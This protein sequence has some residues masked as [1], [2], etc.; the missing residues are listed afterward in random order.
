MHGA[1]DY[2]IKPCS[3]RQIEITVTRAMRYRETK[4]GNGSFGKSC[5]FERFGIIGDSLKLETTLDAAAKAASGK[6]S[7]LIS[8]ETGTGKELLSRAIHGNSPRKDGPFLVMDCTNIP[9]T[10]AESIM[11]GHVKG[12][13]T[14]ATEAQEGLF[15]LADGGTLFLDEV[16]ELKPSLQKSLLRVLQDRRFRPVG[17]AKEYTSDFCLISATNRDLKAMV[18]KGK[19]RQ[20][21]YYRLTGISINIPPLRSRPSDINAL[22]DHYIQRVCDE[23]KGQ[24]KTVSNCYRKAMTNYPWPGNVRELINAV[25]YSIESALHE[26]VLLVQ[27]LPLEIRVHNVRNNVTDPH[28]RMDA[29]L[30]DGRESGTLGI[31]ISDILADKESLPDYKYT[32]NVTVERVE[33]HYFKALIEAS[34]GSLE[35]ACEISGLSKARLYELLKKHDMRLKARV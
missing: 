20:D 1:W 10:L 8:G 4:N 33:D 26:D 18:E 24:C 15:K 16:G 27:H 34:E 14:G 11:Y 32:R 12:A 19:F 2:L 30:P 22:L 28:V 7:V 29:I 13:F 17:S 6:I 3:N 31:D 35:K 21:L 23:R 25:Y 9:D 5:K